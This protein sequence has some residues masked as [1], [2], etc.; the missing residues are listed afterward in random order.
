VSHLKIIFNLLL[1]QGVVKK[2]QS[3]EKMLIS[4]KL[5]D[6]KDAKKLALVFSFILECDK[7]TESFHYPGKRLVRRK[8][9]DAFLIDRKH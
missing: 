3:L 1:F 9:M 8:T 5:D 4:V 2:P 7:M 6:G